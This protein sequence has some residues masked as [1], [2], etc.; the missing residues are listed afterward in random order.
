MNAGSISLYHNICLTREIMENEM[1]N[2]FE[3]GV[4]APA[5]GDDVT[6]LTF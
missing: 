2:E 5:E 6:Q 4:L 1:N 3:R